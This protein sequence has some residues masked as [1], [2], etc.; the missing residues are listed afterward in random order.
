MSHRFSQPD[1]TFAYQPVVSLL[2][3]QPIACELLLRQFDGICIDEFLSTPEL[4]NTH[5]IG[6]MKAKA[7]VTKRTS[8]GI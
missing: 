6:L 5:V 3:Q 8:G 4:F 1:Y 7:D 2:N